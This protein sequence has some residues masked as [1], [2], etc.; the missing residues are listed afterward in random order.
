MMKKFAL[1]LLMSSLFLAFTACNEDDDPNYDAQK[2]AV[3]EHY[4]DMA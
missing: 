2:R 4:A 3:F 1:F